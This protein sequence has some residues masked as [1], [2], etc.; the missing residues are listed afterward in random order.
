MILSY[1]KAYLISLVSL[2]GLFIIVDLFLNYEEL[3]AQRKESFESVVRF[4]GIYYG[5]KSF[6]IFDRLCEVVVL[7]AGMF[8]VAWMQRSNELLPLLS[9]GVSTRRA[10]Q[11]VLLCAFLMMGLVAVNQEFAL[12]NIDV[13]LID[14]RQNPEGDKESTDVRGAF[15][16]STKVF[17]SARA[18]VKKDGLLKDAYIN[19]PAA[20]GRSLTIVHAKEAHFDAER[21]GWVLKGATTSC[22]LA[23]WPESPEQILRPLGDGDY[24]LKTKDLDLETMTR[25]KNWY[26]YL[27]TWRL[28]KELDRP[29]NVQR[30]FVALNFHTRLTRPLVGVILVLM[31]LSVILRDQNRNVF[32]SA[33]LCLGLCGVFYATLFACQSLGLNY[34]PPAFAAWIPVFIFGPLSA[35]MYAEVHT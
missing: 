24:F 35:L 20:Q 25:S 3:T 1:F 12:P 33:G 4:I 19:I 23:T 30:A 22:D 31:G 7:L 17:L 29:D 21:E 28:L 11:P 5:Y 27:P 8:S 9:A 14:N 2:V 32:V 18:V 34:V 26:Q 6:V 10:V 15:D 13:W 16:P